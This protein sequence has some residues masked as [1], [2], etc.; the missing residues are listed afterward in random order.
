MRS[1]F[2]QGN[3][4]TGGNV[5]HDNSSA[6]LDYLAAG[7]TAV[8][9]TTYSN[10]YGLF[11]LVGGVNT[12]ADSL[13]GYSTSVVLAP[14]VAADVSM[15]GPTILKNATLAFGGIS[16]A[17]FN[18]NG[19]SL[20]SY[21]QN[22]VLGSLAVYGDAVIAASTVTLNYASELYASTSTVPKLMRGTGH[23]ATV[24]STNDASAISQIITM[25]YSASGADWVVTGSSTPGTL[26]TLTQGQTNVNCGQFTLSV[27]NTSPNDGDMLDF[28]LI[29]ASN[30]ANVQP[31]NLLLRQ[32]GGERQVDVE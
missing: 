17:S 8:G 24:N 13:L 15:S 20:W 28:A 5:M 25:T 32:V 22:G 16:T 29:A 19:Y 31:K 27:S 21:K 14:D 26:C 6:G 10:N 9:E 11:S 7:N 1:F 18:T 23:T 2:P 4:I 30:D 3:N 12:I